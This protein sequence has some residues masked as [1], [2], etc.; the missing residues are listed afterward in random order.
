MADPERVR[1]AGDAAAWR[2]WGPYLSERQ[3]GTVRE[4][5]SA[6]GDAWTFFPHDHARS[7]AYRWGEDGLGG[8]CDQ[9]QILCFAFAFWNGR[10]PILKERIFGLTGRE[11]NHGEDAKEYWWF[12]DATPT[13]SWMRWRYVYPH[14]EFPYRRLIEENGRR[15]RAQP[16]FELEDTGVLEQGYWDIS[17]EYAKAG[18]DDI[19]IWLTLHNEGESEETLHVL[20]TLWF[21][22]QWSWDPS[23]ARP[24]LSAEDGRIVAEHRELGR[25]VL[26]GSGEPELMFCENETNLHDVWG[27]DN[28]TP[29]PKDGIDDHVIRGAPTVNPDRGGTKA[30]MWYRLQV[31]PG[32][33]REVRLRLASRSHDVGEDWEMT[34]SARAR[35]A[36]QFYAAVRG[37]AGDDEARIMRQALAGM[38][39]SRQFY[40]F[41]V[42][43]WLDGDPGQPP[44]PPSRRSGRNAGW[45]HLDSF[46]VISMPDTWEYPWFAAWDMAF[47]SIPLARVDLPFA[48][49]QLILLC[50]EWFMHPNGQLPAY[51][52]N[53]SNANPPVH[54]WAALRVFHMDGA[55]DFEFLERIFH[56]LCINFTWWVNRK[57][58]EGNN[59]F[60]G[61]FLGLDNIGPFDRSQPLPGDVH[62][63]QS[64]GTAWMAMY[65]LNMLEMS[66]VL[67]EH[68][69]VYQDMAT[70]FFEHFTYIASA[71][72]EQGLWDEQDGFYYDVLHMG[73][74]QVLPL[75]ARSMVGLMPLCAS[76]RLTPRLEARLP[77]FSE[78]LRWFIDHHPEYTGVI[79]TDEEGP[80]GGRRLLSIVN[81]ERLQRILHRMLDED[82]FLSP[83]GIRSVSRYHADHPLRI[84][85]PGG[86][87]TMD[88]EPGEGTT[89]L[90]GGNS[91]WRGPIWFPVN[92]MLIG[93]LLRFYHHLGKSFVVELPTGS[94]N[95]CTL[96]EVAAELS[97][98]LV[99][100]YTAGPDGKR[101]V[102]G[103]SERFQTDPAWRDSL[104][105]YEY[106]HGETGK[107]LGAAH[108]TGWTGLV[109]DL[110]VR[111]GKAG[112]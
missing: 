42:E 59:V 19:C 14:A 8:I 56:K 20:P 55:R 106:F 13:Y 75:R 93:A 43:R 17:A 108:Q 49:D 60:E 94:G 89:G 37:S 28:T 81:A 40:L 41:D 74:G 65:C 92:Y 50:R 112:P 24:E 9:H 109:A 68:D 95:R 88:Y 48:K 27:V 71:M 80:H 47:H 45:R 83:Y 52:W 7:R 66:L 107:G 103:E 5:Y 104:L 46:D 26:S 86:A 110:I 79:S 11:G 61:G 31:P 91:N 98:R 23:A 39:W 62:L 100:I 21:R 51:E 36:D 78:R 30:A 99:R 97:R 85:L 105:F 32:E 76:A 44:P 58:T 101:P 6:D 84:E 38:L 1:L 69:P 64:D 18:P 22:N 4:D 16:E 67:A 57:D 33:T 29:F 96:Q 54:A 70:K 3:W 90:Y 111:M 73:G 87:A 53:F 63:E 72:N 10:D 25:F 12:L 35:E 15:N 77:D 34:L 82:E 2:R 102:F